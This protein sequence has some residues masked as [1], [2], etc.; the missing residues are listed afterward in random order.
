CGTSSG[1]L[2]PGQREARTR[3]RDQFRWFGGGWK[4]NSELPGTA[5]FAAATQYVTEDDV[6]RQIPCGNDVADFVESI[7]RFKQAGFTHVA[8]AQIGVQDQEKLLEWSRHELVP[9]LRSL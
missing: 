9:A 6:A 8:L 1:L 4:V 5:A 2:R 7:A 3:A